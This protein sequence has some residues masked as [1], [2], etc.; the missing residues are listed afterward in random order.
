M[1]LNAP[2]RDEREAARAAFSA[3]MQHTVG[4]ADGRL[5]S[6]VERRGYTPVDP[7][8]VRQAALHL[9]LGD[10]D[11]SEPAAAVRL[12][13]AVGADLV[14]AGDFRFQVDLLSRRQEE[15]A[16][17]R[18]EVR[19][20]LLALDAADG[21]EVARSPLTYR[22][23]SHLPSVG[24]APPSGGSTGAEPGREDGDEGC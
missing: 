18:Q 10:T 8:L 11:W 24:H 21:S 4:Q 12:G 5:R 6:D 15:T 1:I 9:D 16:G 20:L 23:E 13:R 14:L 3:V 19:Y 7:D 22:W 17:A 2:T